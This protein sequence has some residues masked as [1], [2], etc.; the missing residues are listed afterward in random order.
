MLTK[1]RAVPVT[2]KYYLFILLNMEIDTFDLI[3]FIF[4]AIFGTAWLLLYFFKPSRDGQEAYKNMLVMDDWLDD[5]HRSLIRSEKIQEAQLKEL[6]MWREC[7]LKIN[8]GRNDEEEE[9]EMREPPI[10]IKRRPGRPPKRLQDE[11]SRDF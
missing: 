9:I 4:L 11:K 1:V 3:Q 6:E 10:E 8:I 2:A 7:G 5:I